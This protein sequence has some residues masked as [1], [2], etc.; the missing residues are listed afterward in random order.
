MASQIIAVQG[1]QQVEEPKF[2]GRGPYIPDSTEGLRDVFTHL[3]SRLNEAN[4][5]AQA[6]EQH[7]PGSEGFRQALA[8]LKHVANVDKAHSHMQGLLKEAARAAA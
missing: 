4:F 6:L 2:S 1:Q 7:E 8:A 5:I 3:W